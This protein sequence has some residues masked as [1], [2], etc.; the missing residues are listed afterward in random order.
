[1]LEANVHC[2][3]KLAL[4]LDLALRYPK[5][6]PDLQLLR[7]YV[8]DDM[9]TPCLANPHVS[10]RAVDGGL[11]QALVP[12]S[13]SDLAR[14]NTREGIVD[15]ATPRKRGRLRP[16]PPNRAGVVSVH[17]PVD[18]GRDHLRARGRN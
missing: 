7:G 14:D 17:G 3:Q 4:R 15:V 16:F 5:R 13:H 1:M 18:E 2:N 6:L 12:D 8:R 11:S 9:R 10:H